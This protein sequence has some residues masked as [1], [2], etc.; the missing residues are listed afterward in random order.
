MDIRKSLPGA[1]YCAGVMANFLGLRGTTRFVWL[2]AVDN[3]VLHL[4]PVVEPADHP[5][6]NAIAASQVGEATHRADPPPARLREDVVG[7]GTSQSRRRGW[8]AW[9][10]RVLQA[11]IRRHR[12]VS[13]VSR[14][15]P[16]RSGGPGRGSAFDGRPASTGRRCGG[17]GANGPGGEPGGDQGEGDLVLGESGHTPCLPGSSG[18]CTTPGTL[19][20]FPRCALAP[21]LV[22]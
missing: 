7:Q 9:G 21:S 1:S 8:T 19:P 13:A 12:R 16:G 22:G 6:G 17:H 5:R 3:L 18:F 14:V 4:P 2:I 15:G 20:V 10:A 11:A